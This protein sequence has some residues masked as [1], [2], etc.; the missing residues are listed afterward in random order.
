VVKKAFKIT[1]DGQS[2]NVIVEEITEENL[3]LQSQEKYKQQKAPS[4]VKK[5]S[6]YS[7]KVSNESIKED[8]LTSN[9]AEDKSVTEKATSKEGIP[10]KAPMPGSILEINVSEGDYTNEG[11]LLLVLEAMKMENE[12]TAPVSGKVAHVMVEKGATVN[13]G[14]ILVIIK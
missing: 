6:S 12:I 4:T 10:V 11:E 8:K 13:S 5:L 14:D 2:Y 9:I 1:V 7:E 3:N